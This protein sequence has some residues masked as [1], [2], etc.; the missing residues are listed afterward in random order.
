[1][2]AL[3]AAAEARREA[4]LTLAALETAEAQRE[5]AEAANTLAIAGPSAEAGPATEAGSSGAS[6][7]GGSSGDPA[8]DLSFLGGS[9]PASSSVPEKVP[10]KA[11]AEK[12]VKKDS[13]EDVLEMSVEEVVEGVSFPGWKKMLPHFSFQ[14][15]CT[16]S[17]FDLFCCSSGILKWPSGWLLL[18]SA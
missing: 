16:G 5:A 2:A 15:P 12:A 10:E 6:V 13:A 3:E 4:S 1:M 8:L 18:G 7:S 17:T 11:A 14:L 9:A